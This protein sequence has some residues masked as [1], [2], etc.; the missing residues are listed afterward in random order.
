MVFF[1]LLFSDF[2]LFIFFF[3]TT[4]HNTHT[5]THTYWYGTHNRL[6]NVQAYFMACKGMLDME[7]T[8]LFS[9]NDLLDGKNQGRVLT[10][11]AEFAKRMIKDFPADD[12]PPELVVKLKR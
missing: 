11:L 8:M 4:Q 2:V 6:E 9:A 7:D 12:R 1:V 10:T 5:H 3:A